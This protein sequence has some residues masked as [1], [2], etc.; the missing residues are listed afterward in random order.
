L[1]KEILELIPFCETKSQE[2]YVRAYAQH[3]SYAKVASALNVNKRNVE[4]AF[5][6]IRKLA[7]VKG[8]SPEHKMV[9][10]VPDP[11]L[12]RGV[13][14]Y[15]DKNGQAAGQWVKSRLDDDKFQELLKEAASAFSEGIKRERP[16][17]PPKHTLSNLLNTYVITDYHLGMKA[18][19]EETGGEDWDIKIAEDLLVR[20]FATAIQQSPDAETGLLAILG[21]FL[22]WDGLEAVTP[23][24]GHVLDADTR[25]QLVVR[26]AIR[27]LRR[28]IS[29]LLQ[30]HKQVNVIIAEGNHDQASSVWL[31]EM[32]VALYDN[33]PRVS[34]DQS[35]DPY[36]CYEHGLTAVMVH[37][38]HLKKFD[39]VEEVFVSKYR[40][41]FGRTKFVYGHLGHYHHNRV[42]ESS[43][44]TV[45]QHRTLAS[46][47]AYSSRGGWLSGR[48]AKVITYHKQ[49]GEIGRVSI[50]PEM[51]K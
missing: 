38:G 43:L 7:A 19:G 9:H 24:S 20:W 12:V 17:P 11:F 32:L 23:M 39:G 3:G 4:R 6:R 27:S 2:R 51:V 10:T 37:H 42:K 25:F 1:N 35:P 46:P 8:H 30:K 22:H 44:M 13:S 18:W 5:E 36:Y 31:R 26:V 50:S 41:I 21:D 15:F 48:D 40:Q 33:E 47:D 34:I 28:I 45:E 14:T 16:V 49:F 29:T